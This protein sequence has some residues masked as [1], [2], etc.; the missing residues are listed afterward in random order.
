[1]AVTHQ[2]VQKTS[3][4]DICKSMT[5][6]PL[7]KDLTLDSAA[8]LRLENLDDRM[9]SIIWGTCFK[10]CYERD[11]AFRKGTYGVLEHLTHCKGYGLQSAI[12]FIKS[13]RASGIGR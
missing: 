6:W 2:P 12:N 5:A 10:G 3:F 1:M 7:A 11:G 4:A 8:P 13:L 9:T